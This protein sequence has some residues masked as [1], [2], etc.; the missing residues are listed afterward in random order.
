MHGLTLET[1]GHLVGLAYQAGHDP[2]R[3][4]EF[5]AAL[6]AHVDG[7]YLSIY[8]YDTQAKLSLGEITTR[9]PD[10]L[11]VGYANYFAAVNPYPALLLNTP[12]MG[13][14]NSQYWIRRNEFLSCEF[15]NDFL[16]RPEPIGSGG[17]GVLF[18]DDGRILV[19]SGPVRLKGEDKTT[20]RLIGTLR[21]LAPHIRRAFEV[22]RSLLGQAF[23]NVSYAEALNRM[24]NS[25]F[26]LDP[27][28]R[29]TF[30]NTA[31]A[32]ALKRHAG[33]WQ[34]RCGALEFS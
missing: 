8:G 22:Q 11:M 14:H 33:L 9:Y 5:L 6:D 24:R 3:W 21:L 17:G 13:I 32:S 12:V 29:E 31:G 4:P 2:A 27:R 16:S 18:N 34:D 25:I 19:I 26:L 10:D 7:A 1:S 30:C 23:E 28:G 15:Y 20:P